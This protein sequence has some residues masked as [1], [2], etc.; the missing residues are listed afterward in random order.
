MRRQVT[1]EF[2]HDILC[3]CLLGSLTGLDID[4]QSGFKLQSAK[5]ECFSHNA[6]ESVAFNCDPIMAGSC[7]AE[8]CG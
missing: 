5:A 7:D 4:V 3:F 8:F 6:F 2:R 1:E